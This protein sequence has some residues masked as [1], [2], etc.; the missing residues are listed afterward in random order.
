MVLTCQVCNN[1]FES[2]TC[3]KTCSKVCKRELNSRIAKQQFSDPLERQRVSDATKHAMYRDDVRQRQLNGTAN[4]RSYKGENHPSYGMERTPEWR[5]NISQGNKG[6]LKGKDWD[7]IMGPE[8]AAIRRAQN[9]E[10]MIATNVR[11]LNDCSSELEKRVAE[12]LPEFQRNQKVGKWIVDLVD[13]DRHIIVE[14]NGDYWHGNLRV[15]APDMYISS[16]GMTAG[17]RNA[18]DAYRNEQLR[19]LGYDVIV[20]W[21]L[22]LKDKMP[23]DI[24][25][26]VLQ[27][28]TS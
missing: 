22:D 28:Q 12:C 15:Y 20:L 10:A 7:T 14:V 1:S 27:R 9:S 6:K 18:A 23:I 8:R 17:E 19:K 16:I 21:E 11:L 4:R 3:R 26:M 5:E 13:H 25:H 2:T 24:R